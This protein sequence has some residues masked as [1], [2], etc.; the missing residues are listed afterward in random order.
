MAI[1]DELSLHE[2]KE[3]LQSQIANRPILLCLVVD[4]IPCHFKC[5]VSH[6]HA[7]FQS[8]A[9]DYSK[10]FCKKHECIFNIAF[11]FA[12]IGV[13]S[14]ISNFVPICSVTI[15]EVGII[16][17]ASFTNISKHFWQSILYCPS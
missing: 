9:N 1:H 3:L 13:Y 5:A 11:R 15:N 2:V 4:D 16:F 10:Q 17:C 14:I 12:F 8:I 7:S 6:N